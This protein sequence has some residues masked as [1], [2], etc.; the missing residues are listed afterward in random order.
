MKGLATLVRLHRWQL[1]ERRREVTNLERLIEQLQAESGRLN[2]ELASEQAVARESEAGNRAYGPFAQAIVVKQRRLAA[3]IAEVETRAVAAREALA[4][5][6]REL[7][8]HEMTLAERER[9]TKLALDRKNQVV[10]DEIGLNVH[11]RRP[12]AG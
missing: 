2:E 8:R 9:R 5:A 4:E 10:L 12:P 3:T 6:F 11:R 7:K 1:D